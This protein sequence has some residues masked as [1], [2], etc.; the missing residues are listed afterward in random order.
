MNAPMRPAATGT[1]VIA[2]ENVTVRFGGIVAL[3][4]IEFDIR[5]G[6]ILGLIGLVGLCA[7]IVLYSRSAK[8]DESPTGD[9]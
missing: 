1:P 7:F 4:G 2:V 3:D 6:E 9:G 8:P 5:D